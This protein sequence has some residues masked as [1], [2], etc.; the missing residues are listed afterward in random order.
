MSPTQ[1]WL[2]RKYLLYK[3]FTNLW[4]LAAVWLYF[5]RLFITDQQV[6]ILDGMAFSIGLMAEVPSGALADKFGRDKMVRIGQLLVG[7]SIILQAS[8]S[9][10]TPFFVG[11]TI[12]MIGV[13]FVS[14]AD[15]AL[16]FE[17]L[18]FDRS[19]PKW[20]K[21]VT[22]GSQTALIATLIATT[23]GGWMHTINPR[24]PWFL[25]GISFIISA[26][27]VWTVKD[28]REL[29]SRKKFKVE[30]K[31][32]LIDIKTG[33]AEFRQPKLKL[34]VPIIIT[35]QGLFYTAGF[36]ILRL[37]LLDRFTFTPFWG[38]IT[39]ALSSLLTVGLLALMH[40]HAEKMS[41]KTV[42][43]AISLS[44]VSG[45]LLSTANIGLYGFFVIFIFYAGEHLLYPF[46][47]ETINY[48]AEENQRAT[49]LSVASF[50]R[51][52]PYIVLAPIIG[53]LTTNGNLNYFLVVW[54][55]LIFI[56]VLV[57]LGKKQTDSM[58]K[59]GDEEQEKRL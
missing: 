1:R 26:L 59:L 27:I 11:Q 5:Y 13:A 41:E 35:V 21:L 44:A 17:R 52:L 29:T 47:S 38:S 25:T 24:I 7:F 2:S 9:S 54:A 46:M 42:I 23:A 33:F 57:Y 3:F 39:I 18:K 53:Y 56:A 48:H 14:G 8:G 4:F 45:L 22:R 43:T 12:M 6:G 28:N 58:I 40:K 19:S 37:I 15:E 49:I 50:L 51:T 10:F 32:Y 30:L 31:E 34:Y 55:C 36:G 16:F 20:R